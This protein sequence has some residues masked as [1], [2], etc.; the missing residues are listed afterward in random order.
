MIVLDASALVDVITDQPA[1]P[2]VLD[3]LAGPISA[4]AHQ[5]AEVVSAVARMRRAGLI[6]AENARAAIGDAA[7][8]TQHHVPLDEDLLQRA[9][10]L[11]GRL[12]VLDAL[13]VALAERLSCPLVTTDARLARAEPP[14]DVV[15]ITAPQ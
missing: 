4:P 15:L 2:G 8:L 12:R 3:R 10:T 1:K 11:D 13:Y 9:L 6:D 14:C 7:T 5:L